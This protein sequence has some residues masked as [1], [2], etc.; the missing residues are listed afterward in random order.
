LTLNR[1]RK[2]DIVTSQFRRQVHSAKW[3][4]N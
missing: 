1:Q 2:A 3:N 4:V